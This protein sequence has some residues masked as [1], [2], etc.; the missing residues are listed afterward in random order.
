MECFRFGNCVTFKD[1]LSAALKQGRCLEGNFYN[2][3]E[4]FSYTVTECICHLILLEHGAWSYLFNMLI[5]INITVYILPFLV[6]VFTV[7]P[8]SPAT[9]LFLCIY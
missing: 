1:K 2:D 5:C 7:T 8:Q 9:A 6:I 4:R 3:L